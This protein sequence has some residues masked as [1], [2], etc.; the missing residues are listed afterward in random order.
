MLKK[1]A[2]KWL[3]LEN[4]Q[5]IIIALF[6]GAI[7]GII[8]GPKVVVIKPLGDLFMNALHMLIIPVVFSAIVCAVTSIKDTKKMRSISIKAMAF[9]VVSL[10]CASALA[11]IIGNIIAP[12]AGLATAHL[13]ANSGAAPQALTLA[14]FIKNLIPSNPFAAIVNENI[15]QVTII[16]ILLGI[17]I[18]Q[19]GIHGEPFARFFKSLSHIS[20]KLANL[21]MQIAPYGVFALIA[22]TFGEFGLKVFYPLISF[23]I[24]LLICCICLV[25]IYCTIV[26]IVMRK[27]PIAFIKAILPAM[28]YAFSTTSSGVTLPVSI[29]C[30]EDNLKINPIIAKFLIPLGCNFNLSGLAMYLTLAA[31]FTANMIGL[32]LSILQCLSLVI[33]VA[34]TTMGAGAIAG[35]GIIVMAAVLGAVNLPLIAIPLIAGIDRINDMIQTTTNVISDIFAAYI[36]CHSEKKLS[37]KKSAANISEPKNLE[38][39]ILINTK[40]TAE[41]I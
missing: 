7:T 39:A 4:W 19:S 29:Q 41:E 32:H 20:H 8:L 40:N 16:A 27:S 35:S 18:N 34:L 31:V 2:D 28:L 26:A 30:A 37:E 36:I 9:Y 24:T 23:I 14:A 38:E 12:G 6:L 25:A 13:A 5:K 17:A 22:C 1:L 21:V 3:S 11:I 10:C 33:T 15:L